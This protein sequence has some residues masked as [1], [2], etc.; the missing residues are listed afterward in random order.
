MKLDGFATCGLQ[1]TYRDL[2]GDR[3][4]KSLLTERR[5]L[6]GADYEGVRVACSDDPC[7]C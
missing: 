5:N 4:V 7:L 2:V 6:I 1:L 3:L